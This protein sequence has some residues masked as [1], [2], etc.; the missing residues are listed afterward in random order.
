[1][2]DER[3]IYRMHHFMRMGAG[4]AISSSAK[5]QHL[6]AYITKHSA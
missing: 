6:I 1:M 5:G 2:G 3:M 4:A